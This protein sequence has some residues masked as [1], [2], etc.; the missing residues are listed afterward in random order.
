M[1]YITIPYYA[2][3]YDFVK[4]IKDLFETD[5]LEDLHEEH[6]ELFKVSADSIT[7][8]H[9]KFYDK[10]REGWVEMESLYEIFIEEIIAPLYGEDF[11]YQKFPTFR[12]HLKGNL[13]VGAFHND[14]EFGH[15]FGEM[16]YII[17][18]T[19]SNNTA[20]VWV[21]S[22]PGKKDF[23]PIPLQVGQLVQF[24]G[25]Q[26]T[27]GNKVNSEKGTRV[28]M[29][30]R[31]LPFSEYDEQND[32]ESPTKKTKFKVGEYYKLFKKNK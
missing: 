7:S 17:P 29:D 8:F 26:L 24:N 6:K 10:Y 11:L 21:E 15:P 5:R 30:F 16:N 25:N 27:H 20:S 3:R 2:K 23:F 32:S 4:V 14:A 28:S 12:V 31:I 13:A 18:I 1:R 22:E 19:D 9:N